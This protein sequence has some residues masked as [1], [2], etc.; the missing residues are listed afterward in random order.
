MQRKD[1]L[2]DEVDRIYHYLSIRLIPLV[3]VV[4]AAEAKIFLVLI[5]FI[6]G[7]IG[8]WFV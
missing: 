6:K 1:V 2:Y 5:Y 3:V 7:P 4:S 8:Q